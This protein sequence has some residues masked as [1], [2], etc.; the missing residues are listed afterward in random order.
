MILPISSNVETGETQF[1]LAGGITGGIGRGIAT[2]DRAFGGIPTTEQDVMNAAL[3]VVGPSSGIAGITA[4]PGQL[5]GLIGAFNLKHGSGALFDKLR[6]SEIGP[7]GPG[8]YAGDEETALGYAISRAKNQPLEKDMT[9]YDYKEMYEE[10]QGS[11]VI[12]LALGEDAQKIIDRTTDTTSFIFGDESMMTLNRALNDEEI[13]YIQEQEFDYM[14]VPVDELK[15]GLKNLIKEIDS[16][17]LKLT[18]QGSKKGYIYDLAIKETKDDFFDFMKPLKD[19]PSKH[20]TALLD[21]AKKTN[22]DSFD[23]NGANFYRHLEKLYGSDEAASKK[24]SELGFIGNR[25]KIGER[26]QD[27]YV[28]FDPDKIE[29]KGREIADFKD[30][31]VAGL[32]SMAQNMFTN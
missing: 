7:A 16:G 2:L 15:D 26:D 14:G 24:L 21:L 3:E 11:N 31:G 18:F 19:Q 22:Y 30:G 28:I 8:V 9:A 20:R 27:A 5:P 6:R 29:I 10:D 25:T 17:E 13:D 23:K 12:Y 1:D 4:G 32:A